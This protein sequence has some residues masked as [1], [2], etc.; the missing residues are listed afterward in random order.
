LKFWKSNFAKLNT[1]ALFK[2]V[3][4][5]KNGNISQDEWILFWETV[6]KSGH[7]EEEIE[8]EIKNLME[9]SAWVYFDKVP[10][11]IGK[12]G[13]SEAKRKRLVD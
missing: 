13:E 8:F 7:T 11:E 3:D 6:K 1:E 4:K 9:G 2:A 5:D 12:T 10:V